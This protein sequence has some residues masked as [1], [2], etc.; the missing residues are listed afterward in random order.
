[1]EVIMQEK[2]E[3]QYSDMN[4]QERGRYIKAYLAE[5]VEDIKT[6]DGA[7]V[8]AKWGFVS[9]TYYALRKLHA[10]ELVGKP[11][12]MK[13]KAHPEPSV[14]EQKPTEVDVSLTEHE[15]YLMLVGWQEAVR[16]LLNIPQS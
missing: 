1:M 9:A 15:R 13:A 4:L 16:E 6:M 11:W 12:G 2:M 14:E 3:K 7:A 8:M 5:I 10:S